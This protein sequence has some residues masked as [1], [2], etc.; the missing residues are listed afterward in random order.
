[1][2]KRKTKDEGQIVTN[3]GYGREVECVE[4]TRREAWQRVK[5]YKENAQGLIEIKVFKKRV[6]LEEVTK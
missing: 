1:M 2:Y 6:K 3:Y 5:E 4:D